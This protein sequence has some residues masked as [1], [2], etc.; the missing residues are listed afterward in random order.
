MSLNPV[1]ADKLLYKEQSS[2]RHSS[3]GLSTVR[4]TAAK[5]FA[6]IFFSERSACI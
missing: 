2:Q 5:K 4:L 6:L 1:P 3:H